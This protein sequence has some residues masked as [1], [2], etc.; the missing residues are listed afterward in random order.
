MCILTLSCLLN[1]FNGA[2][3]KVQ[4]FLTLLLTW[5]GNRQGES[6]FGFALKSLHLFY[7]VYVQM[8]WREVGTYEFYLRRCSVS[9]TKEIHMVKFGVFPL[10]RGKQVF[11]ACRYWEGAGLLQPWWS[12]GSFAVMLTKTFLSFYGEKMSDLPLFLTGTQWEVTGET[13]PAVGKAC[14]RGG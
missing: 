13:A 3:E 7:A 4:L 6:H 9:S 8:Q 1:C 14:W 2:N 5:D 12:Y 10:P 11:W